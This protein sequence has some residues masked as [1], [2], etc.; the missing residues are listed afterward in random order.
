MK[1][2]NVLQPL[3]GLTEESVEMA[4]EK[5]NPTKE[6]LSQVIIRGAIQ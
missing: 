4:L 6:F 5:F 3:L 2:Y 1:T